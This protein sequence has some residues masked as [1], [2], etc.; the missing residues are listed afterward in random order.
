MIAVI[1]KQPATVLWVV[2]VTAA[3]AAVGVAVLHQHQ[4]PAGREIGPAVSP[5]IVVRPMP[6]SLPAPIS[7]P[8]DPPARPIK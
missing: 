4:L 6:K 5:A 3:V 2:V 8:G 7:N 1:R